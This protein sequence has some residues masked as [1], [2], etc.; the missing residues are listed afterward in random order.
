MK[1]VRQA[2]PEPNADIATWPFEP[3]PPPKKSR[4]QFVYL[5]AVSN[6]GPL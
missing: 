3:P 6:F 5:S 4:K 1:A 2:Q